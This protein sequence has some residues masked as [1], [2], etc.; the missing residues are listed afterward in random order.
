[1]V[2]DDSAAEIDLLNAILHEQYRIRAA[3]NGAEALRML[4]GGETPDLIL[5]DILMP[6]LDGYD[7]CRRLKN[8]PLTTGIPVIFISALSSIEDEITGFQLGAVDYITKPISPP[9][10]RAR[11]RTH[12]ALNDRQRALQIEVDE[13]T[14]DLNE[15]R[16]QLQQKLREHDAALRHADYLFNFDTLTGLPNRRM[17]NDVVDKSIQNAQHSGE[18][19]VV[20]GLRLD[21][22]PLINSTFGEAAGDELLMVTARRLQEALPAVRLLARVGGCKYAALVTGEANAGLDAIMKQSLGLAEQALQAI[23]RPCEMN[24]QQF[25]ITATVGLSAFPEDGDSAVELMRHMQLAME[26]TRMDGARRIERYNASVATGLSAAFAM[27]G[28]LKQALREKQLIPYYQP[29]VDARSGRIVGAEALIRWPKEGGGFINPIDFIPV[30]E[31]TG[32]IVELDSYMLSVVCQQVSQ[33]RTK[34]GDS[35][36]AINLSANHF[37]GSDLAEELRAVLAET[38]AAPGNV[39]LEITEGAFISDLN[40]ATQKLEAARQLGLHVALDD[41]GTGY[42]S[43]SYLKR[44]PIDTLKI[45]RSFVRDVCEESNTAGIVGA[46]ITLAHGLKLTVVAEGVETESQQQFLGQRG[47]DLVQG[48]LYSPAIPAAEMGQLLERGRIEMKLPR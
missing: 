7:V 29:K 14:K 11:V 40:V 38:G 39:E 36:V 18:P 27:E 45:D 41:F 47:C 28:R 24:G 42:S 23:S 21:R 32:L 10:V 6:D 22:F 2:I 17:F 9:I 20:M 35:R 25:D 1:M 8:D 31:E 26:Q 30:A 33:W 16:V 15:A 19:L 46:I 37:R 34:L 5:L 13:R 3:V 44:L 12:L 4:A 43:M 48:Y